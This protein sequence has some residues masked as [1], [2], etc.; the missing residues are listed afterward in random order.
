MTDYEPSDEH[1]Q[2]VRDTIASF[3]ALSV[4]SPINVAEAVLSAIA[5]T[6]IAEGMERAGEQI[7]EAID[8]RWRNHGPMNCTEIC[9]IAR[10]A[11]IR[12]AKEG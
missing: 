12:T 10:S 3:G 11:A 8:L 4:Y 7:A 1:R 2:I 9:A 6:L 5:P